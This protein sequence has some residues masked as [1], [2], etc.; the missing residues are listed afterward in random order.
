[1]EEKSS[2]KLKLRKRGSYSPEGGEVEVKG[3]LASRV[4]GG[5]R[6]LKLTQTEKAELRRSRM[7]EAAV[8]LFLDLEQDHTWQEIANEL[9]I[10]IPALKDLTKTEEFMEKYSQYF[11]ELGHDPRVKATQAAVVDMLPLALAELRNLLAGSRVGGQAKLNAIKE[12][13]RL[14]GLDAP[15]QAA[16]DR[17]ELA[18]FLKGAGVNI[19]QMNIVLPPEYLKAMRDYTEGTY[20]PAPGEHTPGTE[21][22]LPASEEPGGEEDPG[23]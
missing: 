6:R 5:K 8:A 2:T 7:V 11:V 16:N 14:S 17:T 9:G 21:A 12:V 20:I 23:E 4:K 15:K 13:F 19:E 1:M 3:V 18:E 10:S 22:L